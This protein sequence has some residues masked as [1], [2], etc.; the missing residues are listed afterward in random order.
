MAVGWRAAVV[1]LGLAMG[2]CAIAPAQQDVTG[3][4]TSRV[5]RKIRCETREAGKNSLGAYLANLR[6]E[7]DSVEIGLRILNDPTFDIN[8]FMRTLNSQPLSRN[9]KVLIAEYSRT[10][11][12]Y[13]FT[14]DGTET[15]NL[16]GNLTALDTFFRG[17]RS[18]GLSANADRT[19]QNI[20]SFTVSDTF[21]HLLGNVTE[22]YCT[23]KNTEKNYMYPIA[24][25]LGVAR[26]LDDFLELSEYAN[27]ASPSD[28]PNGPPTMTS[29]LS[30][31]TLISGSAKPT[32]TLLPIRDVTRTSGDFGA[33][34]N[35]K[36]LHKVIIAF[37]RPVASK[38]E[39]EAIR[40]F[41][42]LLINPV[43]NATEQ[44]AQQA[45]QQSIIRFELNERPTNIIVNQSV[46]PF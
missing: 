33:V 17:N 19:R 34:M 36:D 44:R 1:G 18:L 21:V 30:F 5:V 14:F 4:P 6:R 31:T 24:G 41:S 35:R 46:L 25:N 22:D 8:K 40:T 15:N 10:A 29:S 23:D 39:E 38:S 12:A 20:Q 7:P 28:K 42:G 3:L 16:G 11:V 2:G 37:A 26:M 32:I 9:T 13:D 43:G 27:L 45:I